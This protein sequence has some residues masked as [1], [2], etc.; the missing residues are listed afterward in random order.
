[1][2]KYKSLT[3]LTAPVITMNGRILVHP[4][5]TRAIKYAVWLEP[6]LGEHGIEKTIIEAK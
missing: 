6:F 2:T 3:T 5:D 1:M 4:G